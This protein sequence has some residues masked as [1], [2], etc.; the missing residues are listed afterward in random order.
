MSYPLERDPRR[1]CVVLSKLLEQHNVS[2]ALLA[3]AAGMHRAQIN[4]YVQGKQAPTIEVMDR[5]DR[6][7]MAV[8]HKR[9]HIIRRPR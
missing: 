3:R 1:Y 9:A 7:F 8:L 5:L 6:A 2:Q 4:R